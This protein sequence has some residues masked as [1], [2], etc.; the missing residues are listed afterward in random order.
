MPCRCHTEMYVCLHISGLL[1]PS[2]FSQHWNTGIYPESLA[3]PANIKSHWFLSCYMCAQLVD[4]QEEGWRDGTRMS[5]KAQ[6]SMLLVFIAN[7]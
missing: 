7:M 2:D 3:E 4:K 1:V 5:S 6:V